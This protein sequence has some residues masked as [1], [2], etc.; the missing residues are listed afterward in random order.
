MTK[1]QPVV[2]TLTYRYP[3]TL[4]EAFGPYEGVGLVDPDEDYPPMTL[5]I[6]LATYFGAVTLSV[7]VFALITGVMK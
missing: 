5:S 4:E 2:D 3:R 7:C 1:N 6:A